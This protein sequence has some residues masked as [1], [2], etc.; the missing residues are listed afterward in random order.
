MKIDSATSHLHASPSGPLSTVARNNAAAFSAALSTAEAGTSK[1]DA[2]GTK[3]ADFTSMTRQQLR[4]WSNDQIHNGKMSLDDGF[5]FMAMS[6]KIPVGGG[7]GGE[8]RASNDSERFDFTQKVRA[9]IE[10]ARSRND[11]VSRKMLESAMKMMDQYQG[12]TIGVDTRA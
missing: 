5:A 4:E 2:Q 8:L 7:D 6:M 11:D 10:G 3:Q 9:G 12:E 1:S